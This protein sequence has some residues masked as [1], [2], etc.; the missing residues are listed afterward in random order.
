MNKLPKKP[1]GVKNSKNWNLTRIKKSG[2]F[3][4]DVV[5]NEFTLGLDPLGSGRTGQKGELTQKLDDATMGEA[6]DLKKSG[7]GKANEETTLGLSKFKSTGLE[8]TR[9][10]IPEDEEMP[11]CEHES[12][13][14]LRSVISE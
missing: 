5:D 6:L 3:E 13:F 10:Y 2:V 9:N 11:V 4:E 8:L 14:Q 1:A 12:S 7:M